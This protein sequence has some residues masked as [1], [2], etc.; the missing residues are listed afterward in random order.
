MTSSLELLVAEAKKSPLVD[1]SFR[2]NNIYNV[3]SKNGQRITF[4]QNNIQKLITQST[5]KRK[6]ILKARQM[7]VSTNELIRMLDYV[8]YNTNKTAVIL[9]HEQD[10]LE[11]LFRIPRR[12]YEF[13]DPQLKPALDKGGGSKFEMFFPSTNSRIYADLESR[14]DTIHWLH[15]SEYAF[16]KEKDRVLSTI[17]AV[18]MNGIITFESTPNGLN[19]FYDDYMSEDSNYVKLFYP[20]FLHEEYIVKNTELKPSNYTPEEKHFIKYAKDN[21]SVG[22]E[23]GQIDFRRFKQRE[24]K[25]LFLQEY[26]ESDASCFLTSGNNVFDLALIK[27]MY[28]K[29][30]KPI[31]VVDGIRVYK[32]R[33]DKNEIYVIGADTA[34]GVEGDASAAHVFEVRSREQVASFHSNKIKPSEFAQVLKKMAEMYDVG[35]PGPLLAVERNNHGHAVILYLDEVLGYTNLFRTKKENKKTDM[36]EVRIGWTTDRVTRPLM[37]DTLIEGVEHGTITLNDKDTLAQCLTLVN[38]DGKIEAE[39]GKHDDL[40]IAAAI[41]IQMCIEEGVFALYDNIA[42]KIKI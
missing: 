6:I 26:P 41:S 23:P 18:P 38:N 12:A 25:N 30:P 20:W 42:G 22:I 32:R 15:V 40:V 7:G 9:A 28:D 13:L 33:V 34:E 2:L 14:G 27:P 37:I 10:G 36:D 19:H 1:T 3:I 24:L 31:E 29:A 5:A 4:K 39:E 16:V 35:Y 8:L 21:Y 11:K 17:E